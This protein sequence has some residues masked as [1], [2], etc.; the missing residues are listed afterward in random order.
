MIE[1]IFS[2]KVGSK[3]LTTMGRKPYKEFYLNELSKE[4]HIGL[5]RTKT[6][7]DKL[8]DE[9]ILLRRKSGNRH[10]FRLNPDNNLTFEIIRLANLSAFLKL[11]DRFKPVLNRF[12]GKCK[13]LLGDNM[14]SLIIFGSVA[15]GTAGKR[16][17]MDIFMIVKSKP[18]E[19]TM[20]LFREVGYGISDIFS[21]TTQEHL[22][23]QNDF[24][25]DYNIGDDFLVN[26]MA[27]GIVLFDKE[28]FLAGYLL[29]GPPEITKKSI[30]K[31][32]DFAKERLDECT[33]Y[34]DKFHCSTA[35][36]LKTVSISLSRAALMLNHIV[37]GSKH[38]IPRQ[39]KS[40][41]EGK[42]A[43]VYSKT[44]KWFDE[45]P[46]EVNKNEVQEVVD[47]MLEKYRQLSRLLEAWK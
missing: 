47:F 9:R 8:S 17:D 34:S 15:K 45:M 46:P 18:N 4:L 2:S 25:K 24:E 32:L 31:R 36:M 16:S 22:R 20:K 33:K 37:P 21:E 5:G 7:L 27:D 23:V 12:L 28:N 13:E 14:I 26:I 29:K 43:G 39:L 1:Y 30:E 10:L 19:R 42:L 3:I 38:E 11:P 35:S 44:R 41:K 6:I 40:I